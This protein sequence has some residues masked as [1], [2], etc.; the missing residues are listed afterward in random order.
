M[1]EGLTT[2]NKQLI[3]VWLMS[4]AHEWARPDTRHLAYEFEGVHVMPETVV[5][6]KLN[7]LLILRGVTKEA[8]P[9]LCLQTLTVGVPSWFC[10]LL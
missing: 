9:F 1:W 8:S 10:G 6:L 4:T 3:I 7:W 2:C 5:D